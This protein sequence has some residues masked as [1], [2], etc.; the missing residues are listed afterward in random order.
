MKKIHLIRLKNTPIFEQ[1]QLEEALLR[2][3]HRSFCIINQG[4]PRAIVMGISGEPEALL[5]IENVQKNN[6]PVIK[7]FSGGGTAQ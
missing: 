5:N 3:D 2:S 6:I 1:L 7:R 4:S